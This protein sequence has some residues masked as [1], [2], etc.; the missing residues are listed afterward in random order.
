MQPHGRLPNRASHDKQFAGAWRCR[1]RNRRDRTNQDIEACRAFTIHAPS[2]VESALFRL[3]DVICP[4]ARSPTLV[5]LLAGHPGH[6]I[7]ACSWCGWSIWEIFPHVLIAIYSFFSC[8]RDLTANKCWP[9]VLAVTV[10]SSVV[11]LNIPAMRVCSM[12]PPLYVHSWATCESGLCLS[13][14]PTLCILR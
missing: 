14:K 9:V 13:S 10:V 7:A 3:F 8:V 6:L 11:E 5:Y 1:G 12:Q 4:L 2:A